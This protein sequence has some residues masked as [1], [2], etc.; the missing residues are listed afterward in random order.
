MPTIRTTF[1]GLP[2]EAE[3]DYA[4]WADDYLLVDIMI[5]ERS[6]I[7]GAETELISHLDQLSAESRAQWDADERRATRELER[8]D[9]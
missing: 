5:N 2:V 1:A 4:E 6:C 9:G 8:G 3:Y 7:A